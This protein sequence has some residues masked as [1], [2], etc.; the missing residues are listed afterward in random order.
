MCRIDWVVIVIFFFMLKVSLGN[1][2]FETKLSFDIAVSG[3]TSL[4]TSSRL[5][6]KKS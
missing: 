2:D 4:E 3:S 5:C 1:K 6:G